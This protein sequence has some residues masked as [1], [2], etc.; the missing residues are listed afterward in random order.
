VL[1]FDNFIK[2]TSINMETKDFKIIIMI[3]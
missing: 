1:H 3:L 2:E